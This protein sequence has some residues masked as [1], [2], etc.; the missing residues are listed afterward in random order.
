MAATELI[1]SI[2]R[3][4]LSFVASSRREDAYI[5]TPDLHQA[6]DIFSP[7]TTADFINLDDSEP[8]TFISLSSEDD[9]DHGYHDLIAPSPRGYFPQLSHMFSTTVRQFSMSME[10]MPLFPLL[11]VKKT[12]TVLSM[13]SAHGVSQISRIYL[14]FEMYYKHSLFG[15]SSCI[16]YE[17]RL[18]A[19]KDDGSHVCFSMSGE[20]EHTIETCSNV[21]INRHAVLLVSGVDECI[22]FFEKHLEMRRQYQLVGWTSWAMERM[23]VCSQDPSK[24]NFQVMTQYEY[25]TCL[26]NEFFPPKHK[27]SR[28]TSRTVQQLYISIEKVNEPINL[29]KI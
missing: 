8:S 7:P 3:L 17:A 13:T 25:I 26:L 28:Q 24:E 9:L 23:C 2:P 18:F 6:H 12:N 20:E 4:D 27:I 21:D 22:V 15:S 5:S 11:H 16:P 1:K 14:S 10:D 29:P 19:I